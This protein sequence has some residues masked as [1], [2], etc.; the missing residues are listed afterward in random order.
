MSLSC[1]RPVIPN[2]D[3]PHVQNGQIIIGKKVLA[4]FNI[5]TIITME[6]WIDYNCI[7]GF[8]KDILN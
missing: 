8:P 4:H 7:S 5:L 1:Q 6:R 3:F 2:R